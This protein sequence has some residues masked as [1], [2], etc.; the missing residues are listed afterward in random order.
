MCI[1]DS[2]KIGSGSLSV[3]A[4]F[5]EG[6]VVESLSP[7]VTNFAMSNVLL[8]IY[9]GAAHKRHTLLGS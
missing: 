7:I 2:F 6:A 4:L 3:N 8:Y 5:T 9:S 1:R